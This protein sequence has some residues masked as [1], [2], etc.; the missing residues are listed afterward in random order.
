MTRAACL[1][2]L[3]LVFATPAFAQHHPGHPMPAQ[4]TPKAATPKPAAAPAP[5]PKPKSAPEDDVMPA[6]DWPTELPTGDAPSGGVEGMAGMDHGTHAEADEEVGSEPPPPVPT[7][8]PAD[9]IFGPA[10]MRPS[11]DQLRVEHGGSHTW[12]VLIDQAEWRVRDGKDGF[13]W[14]GE[15]WWGGDDNRLVVKSEGE[16]AGGDLEDA[17]LQLLYSRAISPYF[18]LQAGLRQDFQDGP[19][20]TY[21]AVGFEGLAP[22]W[23]ETEGAVFLSNKGET[24][25]RVEGSYDL[26]LTQRLILQPRAEM[27]FSVQDVP[28][29]ELGSGVTDIELGLRLRY[30]VT[31]EF[32]PYVG[33][34]Y[35]RKFGGTAD[36][37]KAGGEDDTE[38]SVVIGVRTWF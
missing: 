9:A 3:G 4:P 33:V 16:G 5:A 2:A 35:G 34:T 12:M 8:L 18:D 30:Q 20:R 17:E 23:F 24:F 27:N 15:A 7:D 14:N 28:E 32:S 13:A 36:Y 6:M 1:T 19:K 26:R 37:A 21:A 10:A 38:T 29:L 25:A 31:R 11:R 22:Y